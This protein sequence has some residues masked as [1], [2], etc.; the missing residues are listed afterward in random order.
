MKEVVIYP[1]SDLHLGNV[2]FDNEKLKNWLKD[3]NKCND[4][5]IV[6]CLGDFLDGSVVYNGKFNIENKKLNMILS[7]LKPYIHNTV[8]GNN[9][10][11][12]EK[13][14]KS[15]YDNATYDFYDKINVNNQTFNIYG[16]HGNDFIM[17]FDI[18]NNLKKFN[19]KCDIYLQGHYHYSYHYIQNDKHYI[20]NSCF[21]K[22]TDDLMKIKIDEN[23]NVIVKKI[24]DEF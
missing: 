20:F 23:H 3:F 22:D 18:K 12:I 9:D 10:Y 24:G 7:E 5:K 6:Y 2:N 1:L 15:F 21:L 14:Y 17:K 11:F 13:N 4:N 19:K 16:R 8:K